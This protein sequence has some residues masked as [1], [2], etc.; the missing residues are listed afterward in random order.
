MTGDNTSPPRQAPSFSG[1][2]TF[3][4]DVFDKEKKDGPGLHS[5]SYDPTDNTVNA[6]KV[7]DRRQS[8]FGNIANVFRFAR[9]SSSVS[10]THDPA[11]PFGPAPTERMSYPNAH[12]EP[13]RKMSMV[14]AFGFHNLRQRSL[15]FAPFSR[16]HIPKSS[17]KV[18]KPYHSTRLGKPIDKPWMKYRDPAQRWAKLIFWGLG[19]LG[20]M[21]GIVGE[22]PDAMGL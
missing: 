6:P 15:S 22:Q 12:V 16:P 17:K 8:S 10:N 1:G 3:A 14:D 18:R 20:V 21:S 5:L 2:I 7:P 4:E 11:E 19:A 9:G 13:S